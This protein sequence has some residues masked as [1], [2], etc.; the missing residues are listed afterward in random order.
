MQ[1]C[2]IKSLKLL[3]KRKTYNLSMKSK[4][5][6]YAICDFD[7]SVFSRNSHACCYGYNSYITAYLKANYPDEFVCSFLTVEAE[8]AHHDKIVDLEKDFSKKLEIA[9]SARDINKSRANYFVEIKKD[10][11]GGVYKTEIRPT[12]LCKGI[13]YKAAKHIEENQPYANL[14]ELAE[15]TSSSIV[16]NRVVYALAENGYFLNKKGKKTIEKISN[17]FSQIKGDLKMA[18]KKGVESIDIF[19]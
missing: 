8:R 1:K 7:K 13:G 9:F 17:E 19:G 16:D 12:L 10:F 4:Q 15:K 2:K 11:A 3:G 6:N 5:H 18:A 14:K